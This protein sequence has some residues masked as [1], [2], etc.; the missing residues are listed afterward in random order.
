MS[1]TVNTEDVAVVVVYIITINTELTSYFHCMHGNGVDDLLKIGLI[2]ER[3]CLILTKFN[4][5]F[6][7]LA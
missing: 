3:W 4:V 7:K 2:L 5:K 1:Y 6:Y